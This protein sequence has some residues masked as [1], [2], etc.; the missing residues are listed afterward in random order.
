MEALIDRQ[1][2]V[3]TD[4]QAPKVLKPREEAFDLPSPLV[5]TQGSHRTVDSQPRTREGRMTVFAREARVGDKGT[6]VE[7]CRK[8][9]KILE[10][11]PDSPIVITNMAKRMPRT[12][13]TQWSRVVS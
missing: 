1:F 11:L 8:S 13:E 12:I 7:V 10:F 4:N 6:G 5:A 3:P 2:P 9:C